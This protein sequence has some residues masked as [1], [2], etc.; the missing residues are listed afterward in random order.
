VYL[1]ANFPRILKAWTMR[2]SLSGN[3]T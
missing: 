3:A 1:K 2:P